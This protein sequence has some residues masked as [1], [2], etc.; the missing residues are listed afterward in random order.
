MGA[1]CWPASGH[2]AAFPQGQDNTETHTKSL[3]HPEVRAGGREVSFSPEFGRI[4]NQLYN[5]FNQRNLYYQ[6]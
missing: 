5:V 1:S 6:G 2:W 3:L 4:F